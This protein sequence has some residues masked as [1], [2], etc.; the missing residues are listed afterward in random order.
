LKEVKLRPRTEAHDYGVKVRHIRRFLEEGNKA[1]V[2]VMFRGREMT[3]RE[4][5]Q[6]VLTR[7]LQDVKDVGI[8]EQAPRMEGR[9][10]FMML[11]PNPRRPQPKPAQPA[12]APAA[13]PAAPV[14]ASAPAPAS[15]VVAAPAQAA[16]PAPSTNK[17]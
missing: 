8:I 12:A 2:V 3:H 15:A 1:R 6:D 9:L 10:M 13:R 7:V 4:L 14:A 17:V 11:A 16:A 5:G